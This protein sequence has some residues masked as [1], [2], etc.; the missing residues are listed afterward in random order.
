[1]KKICF[2]LLFIISLGA[3]SQQVVRGYMASFSYGIL[4]KGDDF[5]IHYEGSDYL[6]TADKTEG[7]CLSLGFPFDLGFNRSRLVFTPGLDFM[8]SNYSL[9]LDRDLP[10]LAGDTL[11]LS[12]FMIVPQLGIMYKYHFYVKKLHFSIGAGLDFKFPVSNSITLT[13]SDKT[14]LIEYNETPQDGEDHMIFKT[15]TV[16]S[17][18]AGL[19]M[20]VNPR[21]GFDIHITRYLVTNLY[22]TS[23]PLTNYTQDPALRGYV[24]FGATYLMPLGKEDDSR[25]L[26]YYKQ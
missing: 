7:S 24:G 10:S 1:M 11:R 6:A 8:T 26:Q 23:S 15:N 17:N 3:Y 13:T 14:D 18:L 16:Y 20:H 5:T 12:S 25:L 2:I 19:G 21:I 22:Y 9:E 4:S